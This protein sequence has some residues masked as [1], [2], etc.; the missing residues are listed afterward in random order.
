MN[1]SN[2][3]LTPW[4]FFDLVS[5][6][7]YSVEGGGTSKPDLPMTNVPQWV[8]KQSSASGYAQFPKVQLACR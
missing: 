6:L 4:S 7:A 3:S 8:S 1:E 2:C 5:M